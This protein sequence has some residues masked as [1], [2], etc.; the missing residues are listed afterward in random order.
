VRTTRIDDPRRVPLRRWRVVVVDEESAVREALT[1]RISRLPDLEVAGEA[2]SA[3][4]ALKVLAH[5]TPDLVVISLHLSGVDGLELIKK[6][7]AHNDRVRIIVLSAR[8]DPFYAERA[9]RAGAQ[10]YVTKDQEVDRVIEA[11][12]KVLAGN[13]WRLP[14]GVE[15]DRQPL[16]KLSDRELEIFR[17][18]GE[19][20]PISEIASQLHLSPKTVAT[21]RDR[22]RQKLSLSNTHELVCYAIRW[23]LE[24]G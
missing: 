8:S 6:I 20:R 16:E 14:F 1:L 4:Q 24:N 9:L 5:V 23:S 13:R 3:K 19:G 12:R 21:Y 18:I 7:K 15:P 2:A 22:V 11:I 10:A 17:S